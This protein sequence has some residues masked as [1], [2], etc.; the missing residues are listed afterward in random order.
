M[1]GQPQILVVDDQTGIRQLLVALFTE[2]GY[3]VMEASNGR[4]ALMVASERSPAIALV[5]MKMP[6]MGGVETVR[7][8]RERFPSLPILIM[9]AVGEDERVAEAMA[10]GAL[11]LVQKPFDVFHL[12]DQVEAVVRGGGA[13]W[14]R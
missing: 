10:A 6:V 11:G 13:T 1:E 7:A 9:T 4:E 12:A 2:S 5:D 14:N 8:L 3:P